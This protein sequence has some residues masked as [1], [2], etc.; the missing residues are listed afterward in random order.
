MGQVWFPNLGLW[1][2]DLAVHEVGDAD[3]I[4]PHKEGVMRRSLVS[5]WAWYLMLLKF[6]DA[7]KTLLGVFSRKLCWD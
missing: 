6:W 7:K 4:A 2:V 3:K 1:L 5:R